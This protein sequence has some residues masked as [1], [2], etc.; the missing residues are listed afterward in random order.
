[1]G[2]Q[3]RPNMLRRGQNGLAAELQRT[4]GLT[5]VEHGIC[6]MLTFGRLKRMKH[7]ILGQLRG[8]QPDWSSHGDRV[9]PQRS[10]FYIEGPVFMMK[11]LDVG[12]TTA[13]SRW[14]KSGR[15]VAWVTLKEFRTA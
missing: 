4:T 15:K 1:M 14:H 8:E 5:W 11:K 12:P 2:T 6:L 3:R 7:E 9:S 10:G 13:T